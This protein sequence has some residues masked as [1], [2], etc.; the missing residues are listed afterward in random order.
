MTEG[1]ISKRKTL[2]INM[3]SNISLASIH[4]SRAYEYDTHSIPEEIDQNRYIHKLFQHLRE[5]EGAVPSLPPNIVQIDDQQYLLKRALSILGIGEQEEARP[6]FSF[7]RKFS[8]SAS[9]SLEQYPWTRELDPQTLETEEGK[10][11][12][13][14]IAQLLKILE[15]KTGVPLTMGLY[16]SVFSFLESFVAEGLSILG[17]KGVQ[18]LYFALRTLEK[19]SRDSTTFTHFSLQIQS[20]LLLIQKCADYPTKNRYKKMVWLYEKYLFS[21]ITFE[22]LKE[23]LD[24]NLLAEILAQLGYREHNTKRNLREFLSLYLFDP[25]TAVSLLWD[26]V[27]A[28]FYHLDSL[29]AHYGEAIRGDNSAL[30]DFYMYRE[31]FAC[32]LPLAPDFCIERQFLQNTLTLANG[33][34]ADSYFHEEENIP[35]RLLLSMGIRDVDTNIGN[36]KN[37]YLVIDEASATKAM[38]LTPS[39]CITERAGFHAEVQCY[40]RLKQENVQG[41]LKP[42]AIAK[43]SLL[44][45]FLPYCLSDWISVYRRPSSL[46]S[47]SS[48]TVFFLVKKLAETIASFHAAGLVHMDIKS[49]NILLNSTLQPFLI[50]F[51][52]SMPQGAQ[53]HYPV[54]TKEYKDPFLESWFFYHPK[55]L[56]KRENNKKISIEEKKETETEQYLAADPLFDIY[57]F[58]ILLKNILKAWKRDEPECN[59]DPF[60]DFLTQIACRCIHPL[61]DEDRKS[62]IRPSMEEITKLLESTAETNSFNWEEKN[63]V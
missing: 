62:T 60:F 17:R 44:L 30:L 29:G 26:Q 39:S 9:I 51:N 7:L 8:P 38:H 47:F 50:D 23:M 36:L 33:V 63:R 53:I 1:I 43:N 42:L 27:C 20:Y 28:M 61:N 46:P 40:T 19:L 10:K 13:R 6:L 5:M 4:P 34:H 31:V 56:Q 59:C 35:K 57:S 41:V 45:P 16:N 52:L 32:A 58:G 18:E 25:T 14:K 2:G 48:E 3:S 21:D 22:Q 15:K 54:G 12:W 37:I 49:D 11:A 24:E 55:Y